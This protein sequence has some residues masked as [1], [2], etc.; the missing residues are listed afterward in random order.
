[1]ARRL[2]PGAGARFLRRPG[3]GGTPAPHGTGSP[4]FARQFLRREADG[5]IGP[6]QAMPR[7]AQRVRQGGSHIPEATI[8]R[9]RAVGMKTSNACMPLWSTPGYL[10]TTPGPNPSCS[11]GAK[12]HEQPSHRPRRGSV[13]SESALQRAA[14][15]ARGLARQTDTAIVVSRVADIRQ[16][17][18][19]AVLP[20][21]LRFVCGSAL[22][23]SS[24][25]RT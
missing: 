20:E 21:R 4:T 2:C 13:P 9:C 24:K 1:M 25:L 15:R 8:Q 14:Q 10:R 6:E 22:S 17:D 16:R 3:R 7:V 11:I 23:E 5:S 12:S 19:A 18:V